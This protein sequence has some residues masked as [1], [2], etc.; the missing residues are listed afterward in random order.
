MVLALVWYVVTYISV[1]VMYRVLLLWIDIGRGDILNVL[2]AL[3]FGNHL[4]Y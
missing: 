3:T 2:R 1:C 4:K